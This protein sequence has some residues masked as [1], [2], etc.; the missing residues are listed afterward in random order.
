MSA[1]G[2]AEALTARAS[3]P[4]R[5]PWRRSG[6]TT[7]AAP[8]PPSILIVDGGAVKGGVKL[9]DFGSCRGVYSKQV[10]RSPALALRPP[11]S[12][13]RRSPPYYP[14]WSADTHPLPVARVAAALH[15]VHFY[16]LVPRPRVP[17]H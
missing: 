13:W 6:L 11:R 17:A 3:C 2:G 15:G 16:A 10:R 8:P 9:A 7:A 5:A 12:S 1:T 14:P 4:L